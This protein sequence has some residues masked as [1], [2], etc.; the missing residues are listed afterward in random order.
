M[1][2]AA[3]PENLTP[4]LAEVRVRMATTDEY[5]E[6]G[7]TNEDRRLLITLAANFTNLKE[8][9][10][11]RLALIETERA[12]K[13]DLL[14]IERELRAGLDKKADRAE[15]PF[16]TVGE[17]RAS[18]AALSNKVNWAYAFGAGGAAACSA[19]TYM[20]TAFFK[21]GG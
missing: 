4:A 10:E 18:V 9:S 7:F 14:R 16:D 3:V 19:I 2:G 17:L 15:I 1:E 6:V 21:H 13:D 20:L 5:G 12:H 8:S 11:R